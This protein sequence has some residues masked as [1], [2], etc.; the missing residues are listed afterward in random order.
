MQIYS[1]CHNIKVDGS[2]WITDL[3]PNGA[4]WAWD[5]EYWVLWLLNYIGSTWTGYEYL[6][7]AYYRGTHFYK[8]MTI[9]PYSLAD[10][11]GPLGPVN[12]YAWVKKGEDFRAMTQAGFLIYR[13]V[14]DPATPWDDR[15]Q[16]TGIGTGGGTDVEVHFTPEDFVSGAGPASQ[17]DDILVHE[18]VHGLRMMQGVFDQT[19]TGPQ[20]RGYDNDEEF[21]A[22]L[23]SNI[24]VSEKKGPTAV[25]RKDHHGHQ[26]LPAAE[27]DSDGF[28]LNNMENLFWI[29]Y[30]YPQEQAFFH[31]VAS[32]PMAT[33]NPIREYVTYRPFYDRIMGTTTYTVQPG[34]TL[35]GIALNLYGD[36]NMSGVL[37]I[38]NRDV[39]GPDPNLVV[40]GQVL[41]IPIL[42]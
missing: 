41:T 16:I 33:F 32:N 25:L 4:Y 42:A 19:P 20:D 8:D 17:P 15:F 2:S 29:R 21:F 26:V 36:A 11:A 13:G 14:D 40:P 9:V 1:N 35:S 12:A 23:M 30:L 10:R 31:S 28:L 3:P 39:I 22:I 6:L 38:M 18:M 37:Y 34:D 24:Y 27:S 5:H 7:Q